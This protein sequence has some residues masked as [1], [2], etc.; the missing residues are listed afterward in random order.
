MEHLQAHLPQL[1]TRKKNIALITDQ[2]GGWTTRVGKK[3]ADQ[4]EDHTL[5]NINSPLNQQ[6]KNIGT[7]VHQQLNEII[8]QQEQARNGEDNDFM[9]DGPSI[10]IKDL[11]HDF[12]TGEFINKNV[13]VRPA[14]SASG[15]LAKNE[16]GN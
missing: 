3:L 10:N 16:D 7:M 14:S 13:R 11:V 5:M 6:F 9:E 8:D 1:K 12:N 4:L 15:G 2:V